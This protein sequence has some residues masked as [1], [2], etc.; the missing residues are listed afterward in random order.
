MLND[1]IWPYLDYEISSLP[2]NRRFIEDDKYFVGLEQKVAEDLY[3]SVSYQEE[4]YLSDQVFAPLAQSH[5]ISIDVNRYLPGSL[6][7]A[8]AFTGATR[9][10]TTLDQAVAEAQA[11]INDPTTSPE[12]VASNQTFLQSVANRQP[13]PNYLRPFIHGRNIGGVD[14][15]DTSAYLAQ[16]NYDFDFSDNKWLGMLGFHRLTGFASGNNNVSHSWRF[17][18]AAEY[19]PG[20]IE[21]DRGSDRPSRWFVPVFYIGDAVQPGDTGLNI[22][23]IPGNTRPGLGT[24]LPYYGFDNSTS[25][26][27]QWGVAGDTKWRRHTIEGSTALTEID[28]TA[29]GG[30]LQ[31]FWWDRRI[32]TSLGY[33]KDTVENFEFLRWDLPANANNPLVIAER[34][35][36]GL[37]TA[38]SDYIRYDIPGDG[39]ADDD[40]L[41]NDPTSTQRSTEDLMTKGVVFHV[42]PWLR[43]FYNESENFELTEPTEDGFGRINDPQSGETEEYGIGISLW[44]NKV[45]L[46]LS[47]YETSQRNQLS[48]AI[49]LDQRLNSFEGSLFRTL[50]ALDQ[51]RQ[52]GET[53]DYDIS[54]WQIIAG[55]DSSDNPIIEFPGER[56]PQL[57]TDGNP[58]VDQDGNVRYDYLGEFEPVTNPGVT[59]DSVSEG[60]EM[61]AT[62][63]PTR[64]LRIMANVSKLEN[65]RSNLERQVLEYMDKRDSYWDPFF[66][67][68][69][70][71]NG[72][73]DAT[74][75]IPND[76]PR[77]DDPNFMPGNNE[78]IG[79][80]APVESLLIDDF[81]NALGV[82]LLDA[83]RDD[84]TA[85]IG[86]SEYNA[87]VT[88]NYQFYEGFLNGF[89]FGTNLRWESGKVFGYPVIQRDLGALPPGFP[90][91]DLNGNGLIDPD[92]FNLVQDDV[93]NPYTSESFITG[94]VMMAYRTKIFND[95]FN[96]RIQLNV[97]NLFKQGGDL[98]IIRVNP[99]QSPIYGINVPT[100]FRLTSSIS[101]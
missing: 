29:W 52:D 101:W 46:R 24:S 83:I 69:Y 37:G 44:N 75:Y 96:W 57:D 26:R 28:A 58:V 38:S 89:S 41:L 40:W 16:L 30:S 92:E 3:L 39:T 45:D 34:E 76:D 10:G 71:T 23:G 79:D 80:P 66:S 1:S 36:R 20:V 50:S 74:V 91:P 12:D 27:G 47:A 4:S 95:K 55:L 35:R 21:D 31:S 99:D 67:A 82:E 61:S 59:Q 63:N 53:T 100:T 78:R 77:L 13:N 19:T 33:R 88:A 98:R 56:T 8:G 97:D 70:H 17:T 84:G 15:L 49:R 64:N 93:S 7:N 6:D 22:T 9:N 90:N 65:R 14:Q 85:N 11:L 73:N 2:G 81:Y 87:R 43:A 32:V 54:D 18:G 62:F 72:D 86:I 48:G 51:R 94:G 42:T 5:A 60:W 68:G 25:S